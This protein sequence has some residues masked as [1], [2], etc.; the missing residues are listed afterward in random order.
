MFLNALKSILI[1]LLISRSNFESPRR[2]V[3]LES[4]IAVTI[5]PNLTIFVQCGHPEQIMLDAIVDQ[6][7]GQSLAFRSLDRDWWI[8]LKHQG[9]L[10]S[11]VNARFAIISTRLFSQKKA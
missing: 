11:R 8:Q 6:D 3:G 9:T 7:V 2:D 5:A 4:D 1:P 10:Q